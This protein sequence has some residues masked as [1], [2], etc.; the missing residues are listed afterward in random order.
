VA[1]VAKRDL[2]PRDILDGEGGYTVFGR[3]VQAEES[4]SRSYL[5]MG[6]TGQAHVVRPVAK[7]SPVTYDDVELN[8]DLFSFKLRKTM[9]ETSS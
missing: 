7:D 8:E 3:L 1:A 5:P 9:I 6:L 4:L 2:K